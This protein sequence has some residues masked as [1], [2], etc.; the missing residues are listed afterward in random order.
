MTFDSVSAEVHRIFGSATKLAE[1]FSHRQFGNDHVFLAMLEGDH[2]SLY[3]ILRDHKD[4]AKE[5]HGIV[6]D[7]SDSMF[8]KKKRGRVKLPTATREF[9]RAR[10]GA[11]RLARELDGPLAEPLARHLLEAML[12]E[13]QTAQQLGEPSNLMALLKSLGIDDDDLLGRVYVNN[14]LLAPV[15]V[16]N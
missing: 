4:R 11:V 16:E 14:V 13:A 15:M 2:Q 12:R 5:A 1:D 10:E 9:I 6:C 3:S 7:L 8:F